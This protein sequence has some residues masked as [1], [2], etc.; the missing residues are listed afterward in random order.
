MCRHHSW[1][2]ERAEIILNTYLWLNW[3]LLR[4]LR[5]I[6]NVLSE[7][8]F[9]GSRSLDLDIYSF[10][11]YLMWFSQLFTLSSFPPCLVFFRC[12]KRENCWLFFPHLITV[13]VPM[14]QLVSWLTISNC[15]WFDWTQLDPLHF[16]L[17]KQQQLAIFLSLSSLDSLNG[18]WDP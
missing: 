10:F 15:V 17:H 1:I 18:K 6:R 4:I 13:E 7:A 2:Q 8:E 3:D 16:L 12:S 5:C 11:A 14:K 9:I